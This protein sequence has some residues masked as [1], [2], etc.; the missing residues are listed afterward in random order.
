METYE[1]QVWFYLKDQ[2]QQGPAGSFELKKLFEQGIL[3][4]DSLIW[5]KD[6]SSWEMARLVK[7]FDRLVFSTI[8]DSQ[9]EQTSLE[10]LVETVLKGRPFV[11]CLARLFDLSVFSLVFIALVT[12]FSPKFI[13]EFSP[14]F[15]FFS[16][17]VLY[18]FAE[19]FILSIFG[20]TIG[21]TL[22]HTKLKTVDGRPINFLTALKRS[23]FVNTAGLGLG[24]PILNVVCSAY[25]YFDLKSHGVSQWDKQFGTVVLYGHVNG[26]RIVLVSLLPLALLIAGIVI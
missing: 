23:L 25:S 16:S 10:K 18:I 9:N 21:K 4:G 24:V 14:I 15:I 22:L 3:T 26:A 17:L 2:E 13:F 5:N 6:M 12:I 11:R 8:S 19:A 1:Q 20:N 7:P